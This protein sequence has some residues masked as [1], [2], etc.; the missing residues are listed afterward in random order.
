MRV[1]AYRQ[2]SISTW[3]CRSSPQQIKLKRQMAHLTEIVKVLIRGSCRRPHTSSN[4]II[5]GF[6]FWVMQLN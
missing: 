6:V 3:V 1:H 5:S 2:G 4:R